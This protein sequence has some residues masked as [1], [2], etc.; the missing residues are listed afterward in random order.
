V[1]EES[2][3]LD[4]SSPIT[5]QGSNLLKTLTSS[6]VSFSQA[7]Q[8]DWFNQHIQDI[9]LRAIARSKFSDQELNRRDI[10][11]IFNNAKDGN[12]V[13]GNEFQDFKTIVQ[14][15]DYLGIPDYVRV[16]TNK[17]VNGDR[18]NQHYKGSRLSNLQ[19]KA[20]LMSYGWR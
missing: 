20:L 12:I 15:A 2:T 18:A 6:G 17:V 19:S 1:S 14:N 16:L 9:D 5:L 7:E 13:D 10:I 11:D 3:N 8:D 4:A